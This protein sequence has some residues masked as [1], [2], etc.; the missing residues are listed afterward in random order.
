[1]L[2]VLLAGAVTLLALAPGSA[3]RWPDWRIPGALVLVVAVGHALLWTGVVAPVQRFGDAMAR[4]A[5]EDSAAMVPRNRIAE[6]DRIAGALHRLGG[7]RSLERTGRPRI[8]LAAAPCLVAVLILGWAIPAVAVTVG[9]APTQAGSVVPQA[10]AGATARAEKLHAALRG[11]LTTVERTADPPTGAAVTDPGSTAAQV[12][13]ADGLFRSVSVVDGSG[14]PI[15]TAGRPPSGPITVPDRES[16]VVQANRAGSEPLV[17]AASPMWDGT[18]SL[19]AEFDPHALNDVIRTPGVHTRVVDA[20]RATVF[21]SAGYTAFAPLDDPALGVLAST[22]P[23]EVPAVAT[24][25]NGQVNAVQRVSTAGAPT[26]LGWVLVED[27]DVAAAAFASDGNRR[28]TLVVIT[29]TA[30]LAMAS[31]G[32]IAITVIAPARRLA[33]HVERL[34][35]GDAVAPLA[36]QRLDEIGTAVAATNRFAAARAV[37][38]AAVR[39]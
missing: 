7:I 13:V 17:L 3:G 11:G 10:G 5:V 8:Q 21:D 26:N 34:V 25:G 37:P 31:L 29:A 24:P 19:V 12:L 39:S 2:L 9:G 30:S 35:A 28:S 23:A 6:L 1:V 18:G 20:Q 14:Q 4:M 27:Q 36:R 16:R 15:A 38:G 22:A 32:W 33:R